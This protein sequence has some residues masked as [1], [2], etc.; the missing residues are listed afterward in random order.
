M[1]SLM[2]ALLLS[3]CAC[4]S[5]GGIQ[6]CVIFEGHKVCVSYNKEEKKWYIEGNSE[7][8]QEQ[9]D[10]LLEKLKEVKPD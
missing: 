2:I 8:S 5:F 3:L 4:S 7:L 1:K 10:R 6:Y 9:I